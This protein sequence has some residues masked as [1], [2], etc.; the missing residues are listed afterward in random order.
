M[1]NR[2]K[3]ESSKGHSI[4]KISKIRKEL[5]VF[6]ELKNLY[7][8]KSMTKVESQII[9]I[10]YSKELIFYSECNRNP[11][12][13]EGKVMICFAFK[14]DHSSSFCRNGSKGQRDQLGY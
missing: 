4:I 10:C 12:N 6:R 14:K 9:Q 1:K 13:R 8:S 5:E 2:G 3:E 7:D 11:L